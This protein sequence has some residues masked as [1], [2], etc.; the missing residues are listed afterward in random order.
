[1]RAR[2][3]TLQLLSA[4]SPL[5]KGSKA[6]VCS[7]LGTPRAVMGRRLSCSSYRA[8]HLPHLSTQGKACNCN[9]ACLSSVQSAAVQQ[10][11]KPKQPSGC[12]HSL[13]VLASSSTWLTCVWICSSFRYSRRL[14]PGRVEG[15]QMIALRH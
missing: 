10:L 15:A 9:A 8:R 7:R 4:S 11:R 6:G 3:H 5:P 14:Q 1:M 13:L 2:L 12:S